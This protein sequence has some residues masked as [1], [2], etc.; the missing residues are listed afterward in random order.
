[1]TCKQNSP[2]IIRYVCYHF[3]KT[4]ETSPRDKE[5]N[6]CPHM[7]VVHM[8]VLLL[9]ARNTTF[10]NSNSTHTITFNHSVRN[11]SVE[12]NA[13]TIVLHTTNHSGFVGSR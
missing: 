5:P 11:T 6:C 8:I 4:A 7:I 10:Q 2:N 3:R 9:L 12:H 13:F 1:M